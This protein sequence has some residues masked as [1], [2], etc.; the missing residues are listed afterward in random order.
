[1]G[2]FKLLCPNHG[3]AHPKDAE[4]LLTPFANRVMPLLRLEPR[5]D[6]QQNEAALEDMCND[7]QYGEKTAK[8]HIKKM[9]CAMELRMQSEY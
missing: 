2:I 4:Q 6:Q 7:L 9:Q 5:E 3:E 1:V 8:G